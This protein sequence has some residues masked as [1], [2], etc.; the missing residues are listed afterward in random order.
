MSNPEALRQQLD[1]IMSQLMTTEDAANLWG[2][3]QVRVKDLCTA[4]HI[5][6]TKRGNT[7]LIIKGQD[8]PKQRDRS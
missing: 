7:W 2:L 1:S 3:S 5:I 6:A 8:S 4:G